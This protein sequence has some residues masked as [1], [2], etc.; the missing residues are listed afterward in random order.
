MQKM[1]NICIGLQ[2][3]IWVLL[4]VLFVNG[5]YSALTLGRIYSAT[6]KT[7]IETAYA[8]EKRP[9]T[10]VDLEMMG[11]V[12]VEKEPEMVVVPVPV[13]EE[14]IPEETLP[15]ET[16]PEEVA[17]PNAPKG[18]NG[19]PLY[20]QTDYPNQMY[21]MGTMASNGCSATS[22]AMVATYL[23]GHTYT[24]D[25]LGRYFG[26][27]AENNIKRL[28]MGS[29]TLKLP[30]KKSANWDETYAALKDGKV[31]IVLMR[32]ESIFTDSQHFIV[33]TGFNEKGKIMVNDSYEPNY[34]KWDLERAFRE[35]FDPEDILLG[36]DGAWIYD[37]SKVPE[38]PFIYYKPKPVR[39]ECRY[40][41]TLTDEEMTLL[42]KVVWV[43]AQ[44]ECMEGQQAVAEVALNRMKSEDFPDNLRD[45]IYG[46][47]QFN[48]AR[49]LDTATPYQMQY[50][51]VES[52]LY[53]PYVLPEDVF[54]F[55]TTKKT[56]KVWGQIGG[57][58]FCYAEDWSEK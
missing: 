1:K 37:K 26:G 19:V 53:G 51:A 24:P 35:G 22:L 16:V 43:E 13:E 30:Y 20:F 15:P 42:A 46:E 54:F 50:E 6:Y 14:I 41:F 5:V 11:A 44:G 33:L 39:G 12:P 31:A 32:S 38:D 47:K 58:I 7:R 17:D 40:D 23:T 8:Q 10:G 36:Y 45:V 3:I 2:F 55:A 56:S 52:A 28:E 4:A 25:E 57:H 48:S 29:D 27:A 21:G 9:A 49:F 18:H 34:Y